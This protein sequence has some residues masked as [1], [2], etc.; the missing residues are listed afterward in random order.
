MRHTIAS[1][2]RDTHVKKAINKVATK[3]RGA[4]VHERIGPRVNSNLPGEGVASE[5]SRGSFH[6]QEATTPGRTPTR[7]GAGS[8]PASLKITQQNKSV[9]KY[10]EP[11]V[12][13]ESP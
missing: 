3:P 13:Y 1:A 12:I 5:T 8:K 2:S 9:E 6:Q 4:K 11:R 10:E 7:I